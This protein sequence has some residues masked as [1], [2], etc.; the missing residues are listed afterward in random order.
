[1][2]TLDHVAMPVRNAEATLKFYTEVL[3]LP[4]VAA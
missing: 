3:G 4:R 2:L 1:M